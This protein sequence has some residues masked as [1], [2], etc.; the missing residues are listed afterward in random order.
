MADHHQQQKQ[1][2][3]RSLDNFMAQLLQESSRSTIIDT[4]SIH[5]VPD[6]PLVLME[7]DSQSMNMSL[8]R[9]SMSSVS[10]G[11]RRSSSSFRRG[12]A[13]SSSS[14]G[15]PRRNSS[16]SLTKAISRWESYPFPKQSNNTTDSNNSSN[17]MVSPAESPANSWAE[18]PP[19]PRRRL[20]MEDLSMEDFQAAD[21]VRRVSVSTVGPSS[22]LLQL[23]NQAIGEEE[24]TRTAT[25]FSESGHDNIMASPPRY[26]TRR[27]SVDNTASPETATGSEKEMTRQQQFQRQQQQRQDSSLSLSCS[28]SLCGGDSGIVSI[29]QALSIKVNAKVP[30]RRSSKSPT[31]NNSNNNN[32]MSIVLTKATQTAMLVPPMED[33]DSVGSAS[34]SSDSST[35]HSSS[36]N[37]DN[38]NAIRSNLSRYVRESLQDMPPLS[39][40]PPL[41]EIP[42]MSEIL[43]DA[44]SS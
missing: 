38:D 24:G 30:L 36:N 22:Q 35:M 18:L 29:K 12:S 19:L 25:S 13:E 40:M 4:S 16:S 2:Q 31:Q 10:G 44:D 7:S 33:E 28:D 39:E 21:A 41:Q 32:Q 42:P 9:M 17:A 34:S 27:S 3:R 8:S 6:N 23:P 1:P 37:N 5:I 26:P 11:R 43:S 15:R 20:S 14:N